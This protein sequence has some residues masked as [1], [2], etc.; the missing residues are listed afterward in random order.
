MTHDRP[1]RI[2]LDQNAWIQLSRQRSGKSS[3]PNLGRALRVVEELAADKD[4]VFPLSGSHYV[5]TYK[6]GDP[7]A[8]RRLGEFMF[9]VAGLERIADAPQLLV[10]EVRTAASLLLDLAEPSRPK[11]FGQGMEHVFPQAGAIYETPTMATAIARFGRAAIVERAELEMIAGPS[12]QLPAFGIARP[13]DTIPQRHLDFE[14]GTRARLLN[15]G[16]TSDLAQRT[17][18]AQEAMDVVEPL[19]AFLHANRIDG[20]SL[21]SDAG[22]TALLHAMPAR[23]AVVRMR[24]SAHQNA[25]FK[26]AIGDLHDISALGTAAGYCDIVVCEK[27]WGSILGRHAKSLNARILTSVRDLPDLLKLTCDPLPG[28]PI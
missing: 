21:M 22:M 10:D 16:L 12:F 27:H 20:G 25:D 3:E 24:A 4:A 8:R 26:W 2:Y 28:R 11:P 23:G 6:R 15:E 17:I 7:Q 13:N 5:E 18:Y 19:K 14:L 1:T 9:S